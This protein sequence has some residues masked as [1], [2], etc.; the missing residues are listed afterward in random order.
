MYDKSDA[1]I[2]QFTIEL[3]LTLI[4]NVELENPSNNLILKMILI[5]SSYINNP[6]LVTVK[7]VVRLKSFKN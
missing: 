4:K 2:K 6:S 3:A 7:V 1:H 5:N